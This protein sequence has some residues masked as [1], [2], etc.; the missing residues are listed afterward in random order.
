M[1][2]HPLTMLVSGDDHAS[3]A[4][5]ST[6]AGAFTSVLAACA[7]AGDSICGLSVDGDKSYIPHEVSLDPRSGFAMQR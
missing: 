2:H 3:E 7:S 1:L 5:G 4:N 6:I